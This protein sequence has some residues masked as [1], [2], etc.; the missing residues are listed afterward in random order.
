MIILHDN[1]TMGVLN[2]FSI[3]TMEEVVGV[4]SI[5]RKSKF[6]EE[7]KIYIFFNAIKIND[8]YSVT[9]EW[10]DVVFWMS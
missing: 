9:V 3:F 8:K 2:D 5:L 4:L 7:L 6:E 10:Q 1:E